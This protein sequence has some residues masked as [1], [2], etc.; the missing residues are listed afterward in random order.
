MVS[1]Y[2]SLKKVIRVKVRIWRLVLHVLSAFRNKRK[3]GLRQRTMD[4]NLRWP[5]RILAGAITETP[6][7]FKS[8]I[9]LKSYEEY[10]YN[11]RYVP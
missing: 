6:T 10:Y 2:K 9:Y 1:L 5:H 7:F 3:S 4:L 11:L 8:G